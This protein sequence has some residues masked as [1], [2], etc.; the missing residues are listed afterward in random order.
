ML[1]IFPKFLLILSLILG[2]SKD[3]FGNEYFDYEETFGKL[4]SPISPEISEGAVKGLVHR[5][6]GENDSLF[7][8]IVNPDLKYENKDVFTILKNDD[9]EKVNIVGSSGVAAA[10]GFH[11]YLKY[12]CLCHIS[13]DGN[14][15]NIPPVLP[16]AN[17]TVVANDWFRYYQNVC[18]TSYSFVWW[19]WDRWEKEIDW[20]ALNG[21]NLALAFN[22]QEEIWRRV[23]LQLGLTTEDI[24]T[25]FTGPAFLSWNRMGNMRGWGGPLSQTWHQRSVSLQKKILSRMREFGIIPVLPAFAGQVPRAFSRIFP[26]ASLTLLPK[27]N[28][29]SDEYCC[30]YLLSPED[31][32]FQTVGS[33]FLKE[34]IAEFGTD[35]IYNCDTFNEMIPSSGKTEYLQRIGKEIF[36]SMTSVDPHAVWMLQGWLF[37]SDFLFWTKKRAEALLTSIPQ[38][39]FLILDLQAELVPQ[40]ER[41]DSFFGQPFI[42]CMLH[43]FG[44]T[45]GLHG[46]AGLINKGVFKARK[47]PNSTMVGSGI[48]PEGINQ[49]Y[50]IYDLMMEMFWRT[51]PVNLTEWFNDYSIRRYGQINEHA[52]NAWNYLKDS[53][54]NYTG[55]DSIH[56]KYILVRHPQLNLRPNIWYDPTY[57]FEAW[58]EFIMAS[59]EMENIAETFKVDIVDVTRQ[60]LQLKIDEFYGQIVTSYQEK[61]LTAFQEQAE[62][63]LEVLD[64]LEL[65][66]ASNKRFL[67]GLWVNSAKKLASSPLEEK[68]FERNAKN[69]ITLWGPNGEIKDY[70]NKQWS[71]MVKDYYKPRWEVFLSYLNKSLIT[72]KPYRQKEVTKMIFTQV[73]Q[74]FTY[75]EETYPTKPTGNTIS[76]SHFIFGRW[77]E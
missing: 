67:L 18:T 4:G 22:G 20:M 16:V 31:G 14:Q 62:F 43:N 19:T 55:T 9:E 23:Y 8:I 15:I 32:L 57:I 27:W 54:Y 60:A 12:Y 72:M 34:Y 66:L 70:A 74:P 75:N 35:H 6:I 38:G 71:G 33:M 39:K 46:S 50:V 64:D 21:F 42:W 52:F 69:Q 41:L 44:G 58:K 73:E 25:H 56:G 1:I 3:S 53:V 37:K 77:G 2:F 45:L 63:F 13:W 10:W 29:F 11:H 5:L 76:K 28:S 17:V 51:E 30:P 24:G 47:A 7:N 49:N 48:T 65:I 40:Y 68:I 61:N 26:N 36:K 59:Q